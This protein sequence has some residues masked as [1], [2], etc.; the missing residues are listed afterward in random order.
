MTD[1][2]YSELD[3]AL[4]ERE[5]A[6]KIQGEVRDWMRTKHAANVIQRN[7]R[8]CKLHWHGHSLDR[9]SAGMSWVCFDRLRRDFRAR[10]AGYVLGR[11]AAAE[12]GAAAGAGRG[13]GPEPACRGGWGAWGQSAVAWGHE[14]RIE[15]AQS[16]LGWC[17]RGRDQTAESQPV[18]GQQAPKPAADGWAEP[19][20]ARWRAGAR[21]VA[22]EPPAACRC[23]TDVRRTAA[24]V[25]RTFECFI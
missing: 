21:G 14:R 8:G 13:A 2:D 17:R 18:F 10:G 19:V 6:Q 20:A 15:T 7:V 23:G 25:K 1:L 22:A 24:S 4:A 11:G 9:S 3:V 12:R 16:A 5:A